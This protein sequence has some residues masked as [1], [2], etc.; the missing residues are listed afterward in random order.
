[1]AF[2]RMVAPS[3]DSRLFG[4][5][6]KPPKKVAKNDA[7]PKNMPGTKPSAGI[8]PSDIMPALR[9]NRMTHWA[10][11]NAVPLKCCEAR[12]KP[13]TIRHAT[14]A[15]IGIVTQ[16]FFRV[17]GFGPPAAKVPAHEMKIAQG[18]RLTGAKSVV[19][20]SSEATISAGGFLI[21][22]PLAVDVVS[23]MLCLSY[24][25]FRCGQSWACSRAALWA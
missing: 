5:G 8:R 14:N 15:P 25:G 9:Q 23:A 17:S 1:M 11:T 10:S 4:V 16:I 3:A 6:P 24:A 22:F 21:A 20:A 7:K 12:L 13:A 19:T 2:I 18:G